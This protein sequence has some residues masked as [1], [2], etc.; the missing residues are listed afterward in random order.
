MLPLPRNL[1]LKPHKVLPV[2]QTFTRRFCPAGASSCTTNGCKKVRPTLQGKR[3]RT[4]ERCQTSGKCKP[5]RHYHCLVRV[6]WCFALCFVPHILVWGSSFLSLIPP[7]AASV[8]LPPH[9]ETTHTEI[10]TQRSHTET[11]HTIV[12]LPATVVG[13]SD[14]A[15]RDCKLLNSVSAPGCRDFGYKAFA[16]CC[17]LQWVYASEGVANKFSNEAKFGQYLFQGCINLAEVTLCE[18]PSP[19]GSTLQARTSELAPGCLSSTGITALALTKHFTAI[20]AHACD[21]CRLLKSVD[22][23]NTTVEEIPEFTFVHCTSLREVLLPT[24]LHTIRVKAFMNCAALV[25]LAIPP[26]LRYIGSRA[27]LDCT[28]F[29]RLAKMPGKHKWRGVYA[30][31]NAFAICPDVRWPMWLHM[32]PDMGYT[33]GVG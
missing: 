2:P 9:T 16:E 8:R 24:T 33:P 11:T 18:L 7:H 26:S 29:K 5:W 14:N 12:K 19:R 32:I 31:E 17:S 21:S 4:K 25:E 27:F 15:F 1:H 28:A 22:L 20:G 23:C 6:N 3:K 30:E 10:T 13:I